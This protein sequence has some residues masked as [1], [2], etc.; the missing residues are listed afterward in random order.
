MSQAKE[1]AAEVTYSPP[2]ASPLCKY[3]RPRLQPSMKLTQPCW[4]ED[5]VTAAPLGRSYL[6]QLIQRFSDVGVGRWAIISM[7]VLCKANTIIEYNR[8]KL[9]LSSAPLDMEYYNN[10]TERYPSKHNQKFTY[11]S[12]PGIDMGRCEA[13]DRGTGW[14]DSYSSSRSSWS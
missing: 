5:G 12:P 7:V 4:T 11:L 2:N 1:R 9:G 14:E 10:R 13:V 8:R 3:T 6:Y